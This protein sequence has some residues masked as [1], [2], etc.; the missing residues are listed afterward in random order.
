[1][2]N[3][4]PKRTKYVQICQDLSSSSAQQRLGEMF[5][6][7]YRV[8]RGEDMRSENRAKNRKHDYGLL[9]IIINYYY[10]VFIIMTTLD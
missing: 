7:M 1:L 9:V 5:G 8:A 4:F 6:E 2:D 10:W 3:D